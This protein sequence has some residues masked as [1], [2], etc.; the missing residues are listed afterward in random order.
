MFI[1]LFQ[2]FGLHIVATSSEW[3]MGLV[4]VAFF[5][6]FI[7]EFQKLAIAAEIKRSTQYFT[8]PGDDSSDLLT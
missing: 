5:F 7:R 2:G 8:I 6:T 1:F 3:C 4:F